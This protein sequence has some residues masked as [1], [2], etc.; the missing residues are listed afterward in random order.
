MILLAG[1]NGAGKSTLYEVAIAPRIKAPFINADLIQRHELKDPSMSAAYEAAAMAQA[2]RRQALEQRLSFVSE[3]TFSH[4]SKL[5]LIDQARRCGF[6]V[7]IY[8]VNVR[9]PE[10][11]VARVAARVEEGGHDVP[12]RKILERYDRNQPLIRE[13]VLEADHANV[14]DNSRLNRTPERLLSF[15]RGRLVFAAAVLPAWATGLYGIGPVEAGQ[16][17]ANDATTEGP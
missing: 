12:E 13:A 1:P 7:V 14:Y 16:P 9:R 17:P 8:H 2:R 3:S 10:L 6:R 4:P 15:T 11:S 5:E